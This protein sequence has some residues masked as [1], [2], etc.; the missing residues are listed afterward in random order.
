M[1]HKLKHIWVCFKK[2]F[3]FS[4]ID[5]TQRFVVIKSHDSINEA[6]KEHN[7]FYFHHPLVYR[8]L[9]FIHKIIFQEGAPKLLK[10]WLTLNKYHVNINL[11]SNNFYY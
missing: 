9:L 5:T 6:L 10:S 7:L 3:N 1:K 11:R 2:L 8:L 4:F